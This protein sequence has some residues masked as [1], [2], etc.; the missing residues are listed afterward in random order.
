[1]M[2]LTMSLLERSVLQFLTTQRNSRSGWHVCRY[3]EF[4]VM[5]HL[6]SVEQNNS[7][8]WLTH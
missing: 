6:E 2:T 8:L 5:A 1:M 3:L 4:S 7:K